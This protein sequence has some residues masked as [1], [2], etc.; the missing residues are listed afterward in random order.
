MRLARRNEFARVFRIGARARGAVV[1]VVVAENGLAHTRLGLSVG[2][3][4]WKHAVKR[5]RVRR[6]FREAFRLSYR[7]LPRGLDVIMIPARPKLDPKLQATCTELVDLVQRAARRL[8]E[9]R[10][11]LRIASAE[12][13]RDR[14]N[15]REPRERASERQGRGVAR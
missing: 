1:L 15:E 4:I 7:E 14:A 8:G 11:A 2:R 5:N 12:E 6:V 3:V 13:P 9:Q 10:S